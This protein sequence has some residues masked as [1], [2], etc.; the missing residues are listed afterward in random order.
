MFGIMN[1]V[2]NFGT[3]FVGR[4]YWQSAIVAR[5]YFV[6][7]GLL[8]LP[9]LDALFFSWTHQWFLLLFQNLL[10]WFSLAE[11]SWIHFHRRVCS[12]RNADCWQPNWAIFYIS[13]SIIFVSPHPTP[14]TAASLY[15]ICPSFCGQKIPRW[16]NFL[17]VM[18][19]LVAFVMYLF[20]VIVLYW[21][22]TVAHNQNI[23]LSADGLPVHIVVGTRSCLVHCCVLV[24]VLLLA[25][26]CRFQLS[27]VA[28]G[29]ADMAKITVVCRITAAAAAA[30]SFGQL[31]NRKN[32][33]S[34][35]IL[36]DATSN[37]FIARK[38][39]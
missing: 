12:A 28:H 33:Y 6:I 32:E 14:I 24:Y 25:C 35:T 23:I 18:V 29:G 13:L 2:R 37:K 16:S 38:K 3:V 1:I 5:G 36:P 9:T 34:R 10:V 19:V 20:L 30:A 21:S 8:V 4:S 17:Q 27:R 22:S 39:L 26:H 15:W 11:L 31:P 7:L